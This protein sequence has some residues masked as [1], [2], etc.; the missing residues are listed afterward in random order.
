METKYIAVY[1]KFGSMLNTDKFIVPNQSFFFMGDNRDCSK[2]SRFL[3]KC[4]LCK[5]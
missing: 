3:S 5:F 1:R 2:D 4:W